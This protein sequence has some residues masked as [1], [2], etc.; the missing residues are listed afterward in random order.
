MLENKEAKVTSKLVLSALNEIF[1]LLYLIIK[2]NYKTLV[3][4][5]LGQ[6]LGTTHGSD[7]LYNGFWGQKLC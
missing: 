6:L 5:Y 4:M 1:F 7:T 3:L 2:I